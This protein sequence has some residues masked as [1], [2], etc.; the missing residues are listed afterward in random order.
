MELMER[1][2]R[3]FSV[4]TAVFGHQRQ[5]HLCRFS[6]KR[7]SCRW[8]APAWSKVTIRRGTSSRSPS[9]AGPDVLAAQRRE[10][11]RARAR[12]AKGTRRGGRPLAT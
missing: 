3:A 6:Q 11:A 9:R 12:S 2:V 5:I 10:R 1:C 8:G 4:P 7:A